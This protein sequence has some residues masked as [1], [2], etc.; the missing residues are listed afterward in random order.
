MRMRLP[1]QKL[2]LVSVIDQVEFPLLSHF[3]DENENN[4]LQYVI[5][6]EDGFF[7]FIIFRVT[8]LDFFNYLNNTSTLREIILSSDKEFIYYADGHLRDFEFLEFFSFSTKNLPAEY[9]PGKNSYYGFPFPDRYENLIE[10]HSSSYVASLKERGVVLKI[11]PKKPKYLET[12]SVENISDF[13][14]NLNSSYESYVK[15]RF[16]QSF[17][18]TIKDEKV[19]ESTKRKILIKATPRVCDLHFGSFEITLSNDKVNNEGLGPQFIEW[20]NNILKNYADEVLFIDYGNEQTLQQLMQNASAEELKEIYEPIINT[21]SQKEYFLD[22][23]EV[24]SAK[25]ISFKKNYT[26]SKKTIKA[27]I[28]Q[29]LIDQ[30][31]LVK[32]KFVHAVYAV[33]EGAKRPKASEMISAYI[34]DRSDIILQELSRPEAIYRFPEGLIFSVEITKDGKFFIED[35]LLS[36]SI[37]VDEHTL[38]LEAIKMEI[39]NII[40][41]QYNGDAQLFF[42]AHNIKFE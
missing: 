28:Q 39:N 14:R 34:S 7:Q 38:I 24:G 4:L 11:S 25:K 26:K 16:Y 19:F 12:V 42:D 5:D 6:V 15:Q 29:A 33:S 9:L 18:N 36:D 22:V 31:P 20:A 23:R 10:Q 27:Y 3:I 40:E 35:V 21:I 2:K 1:Y 17:K 30:E 8:E 37:L 32:T 13:T 41:K